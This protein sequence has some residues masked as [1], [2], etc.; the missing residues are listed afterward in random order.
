MDKY[1]AINDG[2]GAA[3]P[4]RL[5]LKVGSRVLTGGTPELRRDRLERI[6][7]AIAQHEGTQ[8]VLV[9]SGAVAAGFAGLSLPAPPASAPARQAA[10]AIGQARLIRAYAELFEARGRRIGQV[11]LT[12]DV[13]R[14]RPRFLAARRAL[15]AMFEAGVHPIVNENDVVASEDVRVGDNDNL[16]AYTAA[17]VRADL[18]VLLTDVAGV[19]DRDPHRHPDARIIAEVAAPGELRAYC[20][21][22]RGPESTGGLRTKLQA[23]ATAAAHG[24]PTVIASGLEADTLDA[25]YGG[26]PVGTRI[27]AGVLLPSR[28]DRAPVPAERRGA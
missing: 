27:R 6:V 17:L 9:T 7:A 13:L 19:Y 10:A 21:G 8:T 5:V 28:T 16:A 12:G 11:L 2:N 20:W 24:I 22:A 3:P 18:L 23:A 25:V 26:R 15:E 1:T 4:R 14:S